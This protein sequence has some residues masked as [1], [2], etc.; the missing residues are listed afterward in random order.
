MPTLLSSENSGIHKAL[1]DTI[2]YE[3]STDKPGLCENQ[4]GPE[5]PDFI[6]DFVELHSC[7]HRHHN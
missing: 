1:K 7:S 4:G 3:G 2:K 6:H 5:F